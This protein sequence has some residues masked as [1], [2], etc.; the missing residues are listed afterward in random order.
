MNC[1]YSGE[2]LAGMLNVLSDLFPKTLSL[3]DRVTLAFRREVITQKKYLSLWDYLQYLKNWRGV[4]NL[5]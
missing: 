1:E 2:Q 5:P 4:Y 3:V